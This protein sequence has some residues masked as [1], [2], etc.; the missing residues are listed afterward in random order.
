[1]PGAIGAYRRVAL[2]DVGGMSSDTL[3]EDTDLTIALSRAGWRVVYEDSARAWTEAPAT[4]RQLW[5]QRYRWS[6]GTMQALWKHRRALTDRGASGSF[7]RIGIPLLVMFQVLLPLLAPLIDILALY[8]WFFFDRLYSATAWLGMLTL[9]VVT[10]LV[11]FRL[12]RERLRAV[13][14]LPLQ[15]IVYRQLMYLIIIRSIATALTGARLRW[16]KLRRTGQVS[17]AAGTRG[18]RAPAPATVEVTAPR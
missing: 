5:T 4:L 9:Q 17:I 18:P 13:W 12:D 15:Q 16:Q 3:A 7:G 10:A 14:A 11:A 2:T 1:V 6:Y 8:G